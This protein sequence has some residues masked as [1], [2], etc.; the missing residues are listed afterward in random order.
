[1]HKGGLAQLARALVLQARGHRF[2]PD[3]LHKCQNMAKYVLREVFLAYL[4]FVFLGILG[5]HQFYLGNVQ[6]GWWIVALSGICAAL[7]S[8]MV[9]T[10]VTY[11]DIPYHFLSQQTWEGSVHFFSLEDDFMDRFSWFFVG[12]WFFAV[13]WLM[14]CTIWCIDLFTMPG[15]VYIVNERMLSMAEKATR[16]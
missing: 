5:A 9:Y 16:A 12:W 4:L 11:L 6:K 1:M 7:L 13:C 15:Q 14:A 10:I 3:I 2:D 8:L